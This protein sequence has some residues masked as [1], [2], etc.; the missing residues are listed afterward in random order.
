MVSLCQQLDAAQP[1]AGMTWLAEDR[2]RLQAFRAGD[3]K[4]LADVY[5][6]YADAVTRE[7]ALGF[8]LRVGTESYRFVGLGS[9][10]DFADV[11][12]E[13]F[14]RAFRDEARQRYDGVRPFRVYLLAIARN[15]VIDLLRRG[16]KERGLFV[17]LEPEDSDDPAPPAREASPEEAAFATQLRGLFETLVNTLTDR[18]RELFVGRFVDGLSRA[19]V[20]RRTGLSVM[21]IRIREERI[22]AQLMKQLERGESGDRLS[23]LLLLLV[24]AG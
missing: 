22:R 12:Q 21:Q 16:G 20:S 8:N 4:V 17:P 7:L 2:T 13:T 19:D 1:G 5:R 18:D 23:A 14:L 9:A 11:V 15:L 10:F 6:H 3:R 24:M